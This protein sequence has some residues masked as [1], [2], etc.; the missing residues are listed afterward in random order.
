[1][2]SLALNTST[3]HPRPS[4]PPQMDGNESTPQTQAQNQKDTDQEPSNPESALPES[5]MTHHPQWKTS[6]CKTA[7]TSGATPFHV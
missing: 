7:T 5:E 1:M 3:L 6:L 4:T 2:S